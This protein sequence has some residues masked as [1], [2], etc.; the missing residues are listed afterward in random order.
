MPD[1]LGHLHVLEGGGEPPSPPGP[2]EP[3]A[4]WN[5]TE[6]FA[7]PESDRQRLF[8]S[9]RAAYLKR[10]P[11]HDSGFVS[12]AREYA[13]R[14]ASD[15]DNTDRAELV[16]LLSD[17][18][19]RDVRKCAH[20]VWDDARPRQMHLWPEGDRWGE[21][22]PIHR[23]GIP[24]SPVRTY[25]VCGR[26]VDR[27]LLYQ[28]AGRGEWASYFRPFDLVRKATAAEDAGVEPPRYTYRDQDDARRTCTGCAVAAHELPEC[29]EAE[30]QAPPDWWFKPIQ[31][32]AAFA[33][34]GELNRDKAFASLSSLEKAAARAYR[35]A[36]GD[37]V[38]RR[39]KADGE[40]AMR[41]LFGTDLR[42]INRSWRAGVY[43]EYDEIARAAIRASKRL[44]HELL[45]E[46]D[47]RKLVKTY[48]PGAPARRMEGKYSYD[49]AP[50]RRFRADVRE[51]IET[52]CKRTRSSK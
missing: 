39:L 16:A 46:A 33:I 47:W 49:H 26:L 1:R 19:V 42:D 17:V 21:T 29:S 30:H 41:R 10:K 51:R 15:S 28:R 4:A 11:E 37:W 45:T 48:L 27:H 23:L 12:T 36:T 22:P 24:T 9:Y 14:L 6:A 35:A 8:A 2:N 50:E 13:R 18:G 38:A 32:E 40:A 31:I 3:Y 34:A 43:T 7:D 25:T 20:V 44:P 52:L 5:L